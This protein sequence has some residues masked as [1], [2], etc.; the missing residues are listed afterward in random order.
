ML[1][2]VYVHT[3]KDKPLFAVIEQLEQW[4]AQSKCSLN[5]SPHYLIV[6]QHIIYLFCFPV[7]D[8]DH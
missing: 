3:L 4:P 6:R 5:I 1:K 8:F 7:V 2:A